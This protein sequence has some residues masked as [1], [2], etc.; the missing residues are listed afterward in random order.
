MNA[1]LNRRRAEAAIPGA[2]STFHLEDLSG[3]DEQEVVFI[4]SADFGEYEQN[5]PLVEHRSGEDQT[6]LLQRWDQEASE[7]IGQFQRRTKVPL[8]R[9]DGGIAHHS[10]SDAL[11]SGRSRRATRDTQG[12]PQ[13]R[14][15]KSCLTSGKWRH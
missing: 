12:A 13:T 6:S 8:C 11:L 1:I 14:D 10:G 4:N 7:D 9:K 15:H 2:I 5:S 3:D